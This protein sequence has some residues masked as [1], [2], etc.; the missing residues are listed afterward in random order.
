[1]RLSRAWYA[2][3]S[4]RTHV[5]HSLA[6][7]A[8]GGA[9]GTAGADEEEIVEDDGTRLRAHR[10]ADGEVVVEFVE[11]EHEGD[12]L[13]EEALREHDEVTKIKNVNFIEL[14]RYR[15]ETWYFSPLPKEYWPDGVTECLYFCE[16]C[17]KF[18]R[19]KTELRHHCTK[20]TWRY[21]PGDEIYR[22]AD[23]ISMWEVDGQKDKFYCQV[24]SMLWEG[25][26][27]GEAPFRQ[28]GCGLAMFT[29]LTQCTHFELVISRPTCPCLNVAVQNLS[30]L[31][32]MFLDHKTLFYDV[33]LFNFYVMTEVRL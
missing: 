24:R 22:G 31:A 15:M 26:L 33:D 11:P 21:P 28:S 1:M 19:R 13:T 23:G 20:C 32:K 12:G 4:S 2:W 9:G 6:A 30:Y 7:A 5:L 17:L 10:K 29:R 27:R 25:C 16:F 3:L 14:G 18:F 8:H